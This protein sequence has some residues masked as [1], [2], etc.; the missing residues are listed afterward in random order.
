MNRHEYEDQQCIN[1]PITELFDGG[2]IF[3]T[4]IEVEL[5]QMPAGGQS[6]KSRFT[7]TQMAGVHIVRFQVCFLEGINNQWR[8]WGQQC[9]WRVQPCK[10]GSSCPKTVL[11][12]SLH[13]HVL[14]VCSSVQQQQSASHAFCGRSTSAGH[15]KLTDTCQGGEYIN[16]F[17]VEQA[18]QLQPKHLIQRPTR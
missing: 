13:V 14:P 16:L 3:V 12:C 9:G 15:G 11:V 4:N 17:I 8:W 5:L 6:R 7:T 1:A 2:W 10:C 18:L